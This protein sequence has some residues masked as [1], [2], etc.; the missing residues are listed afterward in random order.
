MTTHTKK[1]TGFLATIKEL[2]VLLLIV[3][4][5]R[6]IGFGLYQ[7]PTGSMETTVL[8]GERFFADKFTVLFTPFKRGDII[9]FNEP[10]TLFHY[11]SNPIKNFIENYVWGPR[12]LTKRIIGI[13]GDRLRGTVEN[14]K[15]V[16]YLNDKLLDEPYLNKYPLI[17]VQNDSAENIEK[18][19]DDFI[20]EL[21]LT[22]RIDPSQVADIKGQLKKDYFVTWKTYDPSV[23]LEHQPF[24]R[25]NPNQIVKGPDGLPLLRMPYTVLESPQPEHHGKNIW[26][27][28]NDEFSIELGPNEYWCMGDN[29]LGSGD[30]RTFGPVNG[31]LI[32]GKIV[33]RI[34]SIDSDESWWILDLLKHPI[35]FWSRVRWHRFFDIVR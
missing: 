20:S 34:W 15:P 24:Y 6:T 13:P 3:F 12:N 22:R 27:G 5:V 18:M 30:S 26:G 35:D 10:E 33:F 2:L 16:I 19:S 31:K 11:S 14:G 8:V 9:A 25:I 29:R 23:S 28:N 17:C 32:H 4:V 7:V 1:K 21:L